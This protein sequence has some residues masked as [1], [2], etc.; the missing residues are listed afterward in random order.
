MTGAASGQ[1]RIL[2]G[3]AVL[4]A[5]LA[6]DQASKWWILYRFDLPARGSVVIAPFLNFTMVWN[7]AVTFG[8]LG[9]LGR[10]GPVLFC[11]IALL[12]VIALLWH[13][14][15]TPKMLVAIATGGIAGGAIGNVIDRMRFGAVVDF[16]HAHAFGWSWYVFNVADS[17]IVCGVA[18]WLI[19]TI[20][21]EKDK[22]RE[23]V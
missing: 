15:R 4:L 8:M 7:H 13:M 16:I 19:D 11:V 5:V 20:C 3:L 10:S 9:G 14:T 1:R 23:L 17:A 18:L 2:V 22:P 12:A 6:A 21:F